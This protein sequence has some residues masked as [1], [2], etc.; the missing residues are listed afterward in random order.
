MNETALTPRQRVMAAVRGD[1]VDRP[2]FAVWRH[3]FPEENEGAARLA[4]TTIDFTRRHELDLVK[5]NPRAHY[6]AEPWGTRYRYEGE[7]KP[8]VERYAVT[9]ARDWSR[10]DARG[11]DE[12]AFTELLEGLSMVK[13][14]LPATPIVATVFTPLGVLERLAGPERVAADVRAAPER[15]LEAL[16]AVAETFAALARACL[17]SCD[18]VFLATTAWARRTVLDDE[19]YERF[20]R[21]FDLRVLDAVR[22]APLNVLHVCGD[23]AR[24]RELAAYPHV[25]AVSWNAHATGT[26][27]LGGFLADTPDRAA[28]GGISDEAL[29]AS[30]P[31]MV[32]AEVADG[33]VPTAGRRWIA[34]GGCTIPVETPSAG[35]DAA[36]RALSTLDRADRA[37][38]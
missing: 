33:L 14:A 21:P 13:A 36:R 12:P 2:P 23:D 11:V 27:S 30:D 34:A 3:F 25:A 8:V 7:S 6:H 9:A 35:I 28:V 26:P 29:L 17:E 10:I 32:R 22:E 5:Y 19:E 1:A 37:R 24:V 15:V 20:G 18:G 16:D 4:R 31:A 38:S